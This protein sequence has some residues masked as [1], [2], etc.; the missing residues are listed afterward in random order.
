[1]KTL[2]VLIIFLLAKQFV[3]SQEITVFNKDSSIIITKNPRLDE[4]IEKQ[5]LQNLV[6]QSMHGYRIQIYFGGTRQKAAD[7]KLLF[8]SMYPNIAAYITYQQPNFKVRVGN[9]LTQ[10]E[11]EP[12]RKM[13]AAL[14]P[15]RGIFLVSDRVEFRPI[16]EESFDIE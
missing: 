8:N 1:M 10:R 4:L 13:I 3:F 9:F 5:K 2:A 12:I 11:A 16:D 15:T 7:S 14:Y 6:T